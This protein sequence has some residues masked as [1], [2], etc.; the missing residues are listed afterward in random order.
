MNVRNRDP[1]AAI[2]LVIGLFAALVLWARVASADVSTPAAGPTATTSGDAGSAQGTPVN[3][4]DTGEDAGAASNASG[5]V[6]EGQAPLPASNVTARAS[7]EIG[8]Y[9]DNVAVSVLTPS[10]SARV[11]DPTAGWGVNGRYLVDVVSAASPDIV[12]TASPRWTEVRNAGNLGARYKP[13]N[14]GVSV[15]AVASYTPDYLALGANGQLTED[16]DDKNLTLVQ[17]YGFGHDVIGRTGTSFSAFSRQL[18]YHTLTLGA[19]RVVNPSLVLGV[20]ADA[21]IE[22]GDQ[23]KPYRYI[24]IFTP[25]AAAKIPRGASPDLVA[26]TRLQARPLEQ[27]P[28]ERERGAITGRLAWRLATSTVRV[29]ERFYADTWGLR[30]TTTDARWLFDVSDRITFWPHLRIHL[31]NSVDFW[32]RAYFARDAHDIPALRTG[33]RELAALSN[34]GLGGGLRLAL[35]KRGRLDD[36]VLTT[37]LDGTWTSFADAIYVTDRLSALAVTSLEVAF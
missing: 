22:R 7:I 16:L 30:A 37:T 8:A 9:Q 4:A 25:E 18:D 32:Q 19:S 17:G 28:L 24:P 6:P 2:V 15:G 34:L 5:S 10:I 31:Q 3:D 36:F 12:S 23:S 11:E 27:L 20:F 1:N 21:I 29:E 13:G 14:L 35:G 26:N 33:D